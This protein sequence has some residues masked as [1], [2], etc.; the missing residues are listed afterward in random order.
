MSICISEYA[1]RDFVRD[2]ATEE[3]RLCDTFHVC[4]RLEWP[5][6]KQ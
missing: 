2:M 6:S 3:V 1:I 5:L 4:D